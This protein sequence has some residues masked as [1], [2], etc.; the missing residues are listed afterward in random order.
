MRGPA[1]ARRGKVRRF[2]FFFSVTSRAAAGD[3][4]FLH[5]FKSTLKCGGVYADGGG[6]RRRAVWFVPRGV[7]TRRAKRMTGSDKGN[8]CFVRAA[9]RRLCACKLAPSAVF[10]HPRDMWTNL[11]LRLWYLPSRIFTTNARPRRLFFFFTV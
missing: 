5:L 8:S 1:S 10:N 11:N 4:A 7:S 9:R 2:T 3:D 6:E